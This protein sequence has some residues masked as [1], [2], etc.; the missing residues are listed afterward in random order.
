MT[1]LEAITASIGIPIPPYSESS[2]QKAL[3]D[4][5]LDPAGI[6]SIDSKTTIS[7]AA[8]VVIKGLLGLKSIQ[9]GDFAV[10]YDLQGRLKQIESDL[11]LA[12]GA[13]VRNASCYW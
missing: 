7:Y 2:L 10:V 5:G 3:L 11:G 4:A 6:Y 1:N 8:L 13:I 12:T 9:E